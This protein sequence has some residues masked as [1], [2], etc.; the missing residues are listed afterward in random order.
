MQ[1]FYP[2]M[3]RILLL[4]LMMFFVSLALE[5]QPT[6]LPD[7]RLS[8]DEELRKAYSS[9]ASDSIAHVYD[10]TTLTVDDYL[11]KYHEMPNINL[12]GSGTVR[13]ENTHIGEIL[14]VALMRN[15]SIVGAGYQI[16]SADASVIQA[17]SIHGA[18]LTGNFQ[19]IRID[20]VPKSA[21]GISMG[22]RD[23]QTAYVEITQPIFLS[24]K[25][26]AMVNSARLGRNIAGSG[27]TLAAQNVLREAVFRWLGW[28]FAREA[29][30]VGFKDLELA[31]AHR[32]LV[33]ARYKHKQ[34]SQFEV[35]RAEVRL[36]QAQ[37]DLRRQTNSK[38]LAA[39]DLL[40]T[41]D[42]PQNTEVTTEERL[43]MIDFVVD[44]D[45]DSAESLMLRE[46]LKM[47]R[48]E[49]QL[50]HEALAAARSENKPVVS[51]FGQTGIQDPSS[52]SLTFDRES[53]WRAGVVAN[54]TLADSGMRKGKIK[55]AHSRLAQ[56]ENELQRAIE[57]ASIEIRQAYLSI[58]TAKEVV[59]A[60]RK[61][62]SQAEEALRLAGVRY[63]SGL[64]TQV[65]LFDAENAY[66]ATRLHYL[67]AILSYHQAYTSYRLATGHFGRRL[68]AQTLDR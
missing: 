49:V 44:Y 36:A 64:I 5:A 40:N 11:D 66:L 45:K 21:A 65:E 43:Q 35:L 29:E 3:N 46:D 63:T 10:D 8:V 28:L 41:L 15:R 54:F 37:S 2:T 16:D 13:L 58:E 22:K 53:Y 1:A 68:I 19:Q 52:K 9:N 18:K 42:L 38:E 30:L 48:L 25:D 39:L 24:G 59:G 4:V 17:R 55:E 51:V 56:A 12:M 6:L 61:A 27:Y 34:V 50:G 14:R 60:Q 32:A 26:R 33:D 20:E 7:A 23:S 57:S 47:K 31:Q 62:L 67:Q